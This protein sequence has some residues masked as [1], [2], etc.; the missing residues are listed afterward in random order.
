M[1]AGSRRSIPTCSAWEITFRRL[2][3]SPQEPQDAC[4]KRAA[5][6]AVQPR[7][8]MVIRLSILPAVATSSAPVIPGWA[9]PIHL[10]PLLEEL[11]RRQGYRTLEIIE[12]PDRALDFLILRDTP[13][14]HDERLVRCYWVPPGM[15][16]HRQPLDLYAEGMRRVPE[17]AGLFLAIGGV[18]DAVRAIASA[19]QI[20]LWDAETLEQIL[21]NF[22]L[23]IDDFE[24]PAPP[25]AAP[26]SPPDPGLG[27]P[28]FAVEPVPPR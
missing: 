7:G 8:P 4:W 23:P 16:L 28:P 14:E 17:V 5:Q 21:R 26:P 22:E 19:H 1:P 9:H 27:A 10:R 18:P 25:P 20:E 2:K 13:L 3:P 6:Q 15:A 24:A 12:T 11:F